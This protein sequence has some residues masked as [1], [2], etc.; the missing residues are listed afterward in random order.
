M[1]KE[2]IDYAYPLMMAEK[3]LRAVY[4]LM[5]LQKPVEAM[6]AAY[7]VQRHVVDSIVM[8]RQEVLDK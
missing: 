4:D 6:E 2:L 3:G 8:I 1:D 5:L 7:E